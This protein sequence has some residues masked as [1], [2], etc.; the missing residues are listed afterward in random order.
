MSMTIY[1]S[2]LNLASEHVYEAHKDVY[3]LRPI[4]DKIFVH[5][6][7]E[8]AYERH[9]QRITI[10]GEMHTYD[11]EYKVIRV[12]KDEAE[13]VIIGDICKSSF[14]FYKE[15]DEQT[16]EIKVRTVPNSEVV[17]FYFDVYKER[18]GFYTAQRFGY[19]EFNEAFA[20]IIN[21]CMEEQGLE[22]SFSASLCTEGLK[23]DEIKDELKKMK[24]IKQLKINFQPPNPDGDL[25]RRMQQHGEEKLEEM[26]NANVTYVSTIFMSKGSRGL[27]LDSKLVSDSIGQVEAVHSLK[28]G[29]ATAKGYVTVEALDSEGKKYT[30]QESKPIKR[31]IKRLV[32]FGDACRQMIAQLFL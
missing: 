30:T 18:I 6:T 3:Y 17:R 15:I 25:V 27:N 7:E 12:Q 4:Q 24:D 10:E 20:G 9:D 13:G 29:E 2:K 19:S 5:L 22:Y 21:K 32:E 26:E 1:F 11:A 8:L 14:I 31:E 23:L 16:K 28:E